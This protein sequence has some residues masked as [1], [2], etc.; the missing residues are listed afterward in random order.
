MSRAREVPLSANEPLGFQ[1]FCAINHRLPPFNNAEARRALMMAV[2]QSDFM[3]ATVGDRTPWRDCMAIF[4]CTVSEPN[5]PETFGRPRHDLTEAGRQLLAAGY[6][7][8]P[9]VALV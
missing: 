5:Q 4:G 3:Q 6:D 7:G 2:Q 8:R 1:L 9:I